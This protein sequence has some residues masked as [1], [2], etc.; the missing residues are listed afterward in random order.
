MLIFFTQFPFLPLALCTGYA[1]EL[2][3]DQRVYSR[4]TQ[5]HC[6]GGHIFRSLIHSEEHRYIYGEEKE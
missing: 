4:A 6:S 1:K 2:F 3:T 5:L